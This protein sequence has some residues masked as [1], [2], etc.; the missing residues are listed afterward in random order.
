MSRSRRRPSLT[1]R[2]LILRLLPTTSL[3]ALTSSPVLFSLV[4]SHNLTSQPKWMLTSIQ[5]SQKTITQKLGDSTRSNVDGAQD[6]GASYL[7]QAKDV[8]AAV[9]NK[10]S[11]ILS[12]ASKSVS[13]AIA[14]AG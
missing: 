2:S 14:Y 9:A 11:E 7:D 4:R 1:P 12:S 5:D 3:E 13:D 8:G 6:A 10:G